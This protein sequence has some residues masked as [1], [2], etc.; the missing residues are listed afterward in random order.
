MTGSSAEYIHGFEYRGNG[1]YGSTDLESMPEL[2]TSSEAR[3]LSF[4]SDSDFV[5]WTSS[6]ELESF[7][8]EEFHSLYFDNHS[9]GDGVITNLNNGYETSYEEYDSMY[10]DWKK[11]Q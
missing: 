11:L 4:D 3:S 9:F 10:S 8:Q 6:E 2:Y 7:H 5:P 1:M